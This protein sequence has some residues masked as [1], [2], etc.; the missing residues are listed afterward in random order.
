MQ[1]EKLKKEIGFFSA[2]STVM[3]IVIGGGVFFKIA[4]VA[5]T[6]GSASLT[7]FVYLIAG[8]LTIAGGLTVAELAAAIPKTGGP[9]KYIEYTYGKLPAFLLGWAQSLIYFPANI[10]A[11]AIIFATQFVNL[12]DLPNHLII[13]VAIACATSL[14]AINLLGSKVGGVMQSITLVVK[15]IPIAII[16][17]FGLRYNHPITFRLLPVQAGIGHNFTTAFSGGLLATMF[18]YDGWL[19]VGNVAGELKHPAKDLPR[20]IILGLTFVT[21]VYLLVNYVFLRTL[22]IIHLA[23]NLNAASDAALQIFGGFGGRLVT[24]GILISVYGAINGYTMTGAR[25]PYALGV[26]NLLPASKWFQKLT[27]HTKVP[28]NAAIFQLAVVIV[29]MFLGSFDTLT[30]MLV[31]VIWAFSVL[32][33]VAV[34]ILR[35]RHPELERPYKV[36]FYPVIPIIA[37]IGGSF[38]VI[39]TLIT[40]PGLAFIGLGVTALG[41]PVYYGHQHFK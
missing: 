5:Q 25:V 41:I 37:I 13:P 11:L 3:G 20:A 7:L 14:S 38:I 24:I 34:F 39:S 4:N 28:M 10:A 18:A 30:D 27:K 12:F 1:P 23:G 36:L 19:S 17:I 26:D 29:M 16:I 15:L 9:V 22:P 40:Q 33:F 35:K 32:L 31:L 8:L 6:T 21:V 2:I